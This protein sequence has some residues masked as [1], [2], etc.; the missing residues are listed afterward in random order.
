MIIRTEITES[1]S[2]LLV[3]YTE[4]LVREFCETYGI[5]RLFMLQYILITY[6]YPKEV[7]PYAFTY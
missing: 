6:A 3:L 4:K 1:F 7:V 2:V 5:F